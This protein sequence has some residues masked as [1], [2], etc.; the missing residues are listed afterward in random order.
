M[1][2]NRKWFKQKQ[3]LIEIYDFIQIVFLN[4]TEFKY[5]QQM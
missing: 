2:G 5:D 3:L 4:D 1:I